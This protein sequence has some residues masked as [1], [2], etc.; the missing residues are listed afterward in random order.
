MVAGAT[1]LSTILTWPNLLS[2]KLLSTKLA[3]F[4]SSTASKQKKTLQIPFSPE[5]EV[6]SPFQSVV[7]PDCPKS[8][9]TF[10]NF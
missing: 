2:F 9:C 4:Q 7:T 8:L 5:L 1:L 6:F 3:L 10:L